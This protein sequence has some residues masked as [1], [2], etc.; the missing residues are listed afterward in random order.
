MFPKFLLLEFLGWKNYGS[1]LK[2]PAHAIGP[3]L[4]LINIFKYLMKRFHI[5]VLP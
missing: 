5:V 3:A 4:P 1:S 2:I